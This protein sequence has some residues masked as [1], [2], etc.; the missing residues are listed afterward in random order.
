MGATADSPRGYTHLYVLA[1]VY[2]GC[3]L[4]ATARKD[5]HLH[6]SACAYLR[7]RDSAMRRLPPRAA[8]WLETFNLEEANESSGAGEARD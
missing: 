8:R 7:T 5:A 3:D 6:D 4:L 1:E 2:L